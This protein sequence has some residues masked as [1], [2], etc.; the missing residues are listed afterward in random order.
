[1]GPKSLLRQEHDCKGLGRASRADLEMKKA[2]AK[3]G[4]NQR[5]KN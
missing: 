5:L 1:M 2:T 3:S 4:F